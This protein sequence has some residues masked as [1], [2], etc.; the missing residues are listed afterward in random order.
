MVV[1]ERSI[2][3]TH[4]V[5]LKNNVSVRAYTVVTIGKY[6]PESTAIWNSLKWQPPSENTIDFKLILR[7]P[8][9][10]DNPHEPDLFAKPRFWLQVHVGGRDPYEP[11]DELYVDDEEWEKCVFHRYS[12]A[13]ISA[14]Y[15]SSILL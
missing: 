13:R 3:Y 7:F 14:D 12:C 5:G 8:P 6:T 4:V 15:E 1:N 9:R 10:P 11:F 2:H